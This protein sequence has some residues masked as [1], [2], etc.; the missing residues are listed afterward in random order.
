VEAGR[1]QDA[2]H[3]IAHGKVNKI[4]GRLVRTHRAPRTSGSLNGSAAGRSR[5]RA[6][7]TRPG[8]KR[9][10]SGLSG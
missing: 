5:V 9:A 2:V 3:L 10:T 8:A 1:P 6:G 7:S 4:G